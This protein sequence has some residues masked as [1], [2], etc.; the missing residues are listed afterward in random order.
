M[1]AAALAPIWCN[2]PERIMIKSREARR[3]FEALSTTV[4]LIKGELRLFAINPA[5]EDLLSLSAR[6]VI[7]LPVGELLPDSPAFVQALE[8]AWSTGE[9]F[10]QWDMPLTVPGPRAVTV[11][12]T[13][14]PLFDRPRNKLLLVELVNVDRLQRILRDESMIAQHNVTS[15][16]LRGMAHEIKNPL[17]GIRGAAQLLEREL[18]HESHREYTRIIIQEADR[19]RGLVDRMLGPNHLP[20][21]QN[22]NIHEVLER[23]RHLVSAEESKPIE[24]VRDYDPSLPEIRADQDQLVQAFLNMVRNA[25]QAVDPNG[26]IILRTRAQRQFNIGPVCHKLVLR[27]DIIDNGPGIP[28]DLASG[29]FYPMVSGRAD[30]TGLG[31]SIAQSMIHRHG[32]LIQMESHPGETIFSTWL[33]VGNDE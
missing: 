7:G 10:T 31:L 5:G 26:R 2:E 4:L 27:V 23:V 13:M 25:V 33:P 8:R 20:H 30:G 17:G 22:L 1:A 18:E 12:C 29:I 9:A 14:T 11:D 3:L 28:P 16:L 19:L 15:A 21:L 6:K 32:G 24:I